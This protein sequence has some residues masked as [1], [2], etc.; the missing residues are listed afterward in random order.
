VYRAEHVLWRR[1][2]AI[3]LFKT[4]ER[5]PLAQQEAFIKEGAP[6]RTRRVKP[7]P[8][9]RDRGRYELTHQDVDFMVFRVP[10]LR[11]MEKTAPYFHDGSVASLEQAV[12][13]MARHQL[14]KELSEREVRIITAWLK[15][16]TGRIPAALVRHG[17]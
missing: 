17:A 16:L 11:N 12:R 7:W 2:V 6:A 9:I 1:P 4:H 14:G 13:L 8:S 3:K 10:S 15:S 5:A